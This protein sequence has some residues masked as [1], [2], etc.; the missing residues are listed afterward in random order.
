[1]DG[2][3]LVDRW[4]RDYRHQL[5][6]SNDSR[7]SISSINSCQSGG[8]T[9]TG[10]PNSSIHTNASTAM[11]GSVSFPFLPPS[12]AADPS[13]RP[14]H[15]PAPRSS[16]PLVA[17]IYGLGRAGPYGN[18]PETPGLPGGYFDPSR[19]SEVHGA[20]CGHDTSPVMQSPDRRVPNVPPRSI[21]GNRSPNMPGGRPPNVTS[22]V[23]YMI[24]GSGDAAAPRSQSVWVQQPTYLSETR[25]N[26]QPLVQECRQ[27][28]A[29]DSIEASKS[30]ASGDMRSPNSYSS[31]YIHPLQAW[32]NNQAARPA[33][34]VSSLSSSCESLSLYPEEGDNSA[35]WQ[36]MPAGLQPSAADAARHPNGPPMA[37]TGVSNE[38]AAYLR[39]NHC[40]LF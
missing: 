15:D 8:G 38:D 29:P 18:W 4:D 14:H 30:A 22:E 32:V 16:L 26:V 9:I 7:G 31:L 33:T 40:V 27:Y 23:T 10:V 39:G 35:R 12:N 21:A 13:T 25:L 1:M 11:K 19:R 6:D 28:V 36:Q 24:G 3:N 2:P 5:S 17:D 20:V 34:F 37:L